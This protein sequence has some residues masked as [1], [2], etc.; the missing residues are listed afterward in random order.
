M[1]KVA[2]TF[3]LDIS[4][5]VWLEDYAKKNNRTESTI[6]NSLLNSAKRQSERDDG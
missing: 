4:V 3:T 1:G 5:L 6:V 2:K